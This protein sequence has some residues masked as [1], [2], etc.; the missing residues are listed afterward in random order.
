MQD[1][2]PQL[3]QLLPLQTLPLQSNVQIRTDS[4]SDQSTAR[5]S[6]QSALSC[7]YTPLDISAGW[8]LPVKRNHHHEFTWAVLLC[9]TF[10]QAFTIYQIAHY[11]KISH[12]HNFMNVEDIWKSAYQCMSPQGGLDLLFWHWGYL[13]LRIT[14]NIH[15]PMKFKT[16]K[17]IGQ[18]HSI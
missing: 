6:I 4:A 18:P 9:A 1:F 7:D 5:P 2:Q 8:I 14:G 12:D 17:V 13:L 3:P 11:I 16:G 10:K 15:Y